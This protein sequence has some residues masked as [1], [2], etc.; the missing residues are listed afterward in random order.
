MVV[1]HYNEARVAIAKGDLKK[2]KAET[3]EFRRGAEGQNNPF[4]IRFAHELTGQIALAEKNGEKAVSELLQANQQDP[5]N[6]YRLSLAYSMEG[7]NVHAREFCKKAAEFYSLPML[8]YA[9]IRN[10]AGKLLSVL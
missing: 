2:A 4:Q 8:N 6:L 10:K 5:Y 7:D 1:S 9:F 3:E